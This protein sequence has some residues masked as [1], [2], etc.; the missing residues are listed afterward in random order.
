V[1]PAERREA[2][3]DSFA[4]FLRPALKRGWGNGIYW[5]TDVL[6]AMSSWFVNWGE[7]PELDAFRRE[8]FRMNPPKGWVPANSDD[9]ILQEA[10]QRVWSTK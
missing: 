2:I 1:S 7:E 9:R 3:L 4:R 5:D 8:I 10:A 6:G